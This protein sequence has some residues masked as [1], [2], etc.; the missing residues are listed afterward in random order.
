MARPI[1]A[2]PVLEGKDAQD[3][4]RSIEDSKPTRERL[5]YLSALAQESRAAEKKTLD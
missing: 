3:F 5:E 2:T 4:L 1:E